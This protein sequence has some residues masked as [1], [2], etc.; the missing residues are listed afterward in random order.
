MGM[1]MCFCR[2]IGRIEASIGS[3]RV[4]CLGINDRL[5]GCDWG[6]LSCVS[7]EGHLCLSLD[8]S[9]GNVFSE[10]VGQLR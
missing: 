9:F 10:D 3:W 6:V 2:C 8:L 1:Y 7:G 4:F 5:A